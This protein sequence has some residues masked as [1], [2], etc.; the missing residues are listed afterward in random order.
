MSSAK[1][2]CAIVGIG[3]TAVGK[4]PEVTSLAIQ[5][6]ALQ[7]AIKDAGLRA[8]DVGGALAIQPGDDPRRSYAICVAQAAGI[9]PTYATDLAL[10]GATPVSMVAHAVMGLLFGLQR[11]RG[12][13]GYFQPNSP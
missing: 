2:K 3:E 9:C 13:R 10:G 5:L 12:C 11:R 4:L 8:A 1:A 6:E 7:R